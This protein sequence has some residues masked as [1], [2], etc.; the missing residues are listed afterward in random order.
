MNETQ[1]KLFLIDDFFP[2]LCMELL[3]NQ[4]G[5][6]EYAAVFYGDRQQAIKRILS[7]TRAVLRDKLVTIVPQNGAESVTGGV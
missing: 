2:E 6:N 5:E 4:D 3:N 1:N 7:I